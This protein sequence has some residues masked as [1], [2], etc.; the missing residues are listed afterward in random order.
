MSEARREGWGAR[1]AAA[2]GPLSVSAPRA[3]NRPSLSAGGAPWGRGR[4]AARGGRRCSPCEWGGGCRRRPPQ[5]RGEGP[6][7]PPVRCIASFLSRVGA[8]EPPRW[9]G[10]FIP[11]VSAAFWKP[12]VTVGAAELGVWSRLG[13]CL[14][15]KAQLCSSGESV[16]SNSV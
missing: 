3:P 15:P 4:T 14:R 12:A 5:R 7:S 1:R 9:R 2:R 10:S 16:P 6:P 13:S 11:W 8:T